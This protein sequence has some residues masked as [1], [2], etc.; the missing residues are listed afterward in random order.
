MR[1]VGVLVAAAVA[2]VALLAWLVL[3]R[4]ML[5]HD[6][7]ARGVAAELVAAVRAVT[8]TVPVDVSS[9]VGDAPPGANGG[10]CWYY[11]RATVRTGLTPSELAARLDA[12]VART[13]GELLGVTAVS[14]GPGMVRVTGEALGDGG[15]TDPRCG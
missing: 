5:R 8:G 14:A 4:P 11:A 15:T 13:P 1:R 9:R 7:A 12:E 6:R 3:Y 2:L 10:Y